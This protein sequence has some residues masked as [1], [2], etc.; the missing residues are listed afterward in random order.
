[1]AGILASLGMLLIILDSRCALESG[2]QAIEL[3]SRTVIPSL[4]PFI[5]LSSLI[6]EALWGNSGSITRFIAW[7]FNIPKGAESLVIPAFLGGYP[8]GAQAVG[9]S[10]RTGCLEIK[11]AQR[12][13]CFC[14]NAGP[15]FLFGMISQQF[16]EKWMVWSL[17]G[18]HIVSAAMVGSLLS[19]TEKSKYISRKQNSSIA[20]NL[21]NTMKTMGIICGWVIL[22]RI[23]LGFLDR[24][25][26][27]LLPN[28]IRVAIWCF[29]ELS[30]GCCALTQISDI[31]IRFVVCSAMISF[32]G[33]CVAMQT[34]SV[35]S[36]LSMA[37][38]FNG[39][40]LQTG[41]SI[42]LSVLVIQGYGIPAF[43]LSVTIL[44]FHKISKKRGSIPEFSGV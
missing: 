27:W 11:E 12:L 29:L 31:V 5:F 17:W 28:S 30:N 36:G 44:F 24:W 19:C 39:K 10:F 1:M 7:I 15:A 6:T 34:A 42:M 38:Y 4:F 22:F 35:A 26:L 16:P 43:F 32:G 33:I 41:F 3:C 13:L 8:A 40:L 9:A 23:L 25:I 20:N 14:N 21:K 37:G 2:Q 18:I